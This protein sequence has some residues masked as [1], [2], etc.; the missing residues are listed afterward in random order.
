MNFALLV[1]N[2]PDVYQ[3]QHHALQAKATATTPVPSAFKRMLNFIEQRLLSG[4]Q[5]N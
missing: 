4:L 3:I 5:G 1:S 2:L